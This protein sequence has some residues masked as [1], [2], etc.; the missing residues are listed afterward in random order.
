MAITYRVP[1]A[2]STTG[3]PTMPIF[4]LNKSEQFTSAAG[5]VVIPLLGLMKL[6][7]QSGCA[8][9]PD[10]LSASKA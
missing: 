3:V 1:P 4:G 9:F 2:V 7:F 6:T 5:T 10:L 8:L